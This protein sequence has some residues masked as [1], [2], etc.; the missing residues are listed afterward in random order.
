MNC[1]FVNIMRIKVVVCRQKS[2]R[3]FWK[4]RKN[5]H[6]KKQN[7]VVHRK[8]KNNNIPK[9]K[10]AFSFISGVFQKI[11]ES[12]DEIDSEKMFP[13]YVEKE[14]SFADCDYGERKGKSPPDPFCF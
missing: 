3:R 13:F 5:L 7:E 14:S 6:G 1:I 10:F 9:T 2:R 4:R 11:H 12:F 8:Y